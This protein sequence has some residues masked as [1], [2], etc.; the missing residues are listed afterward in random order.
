MVRHEVAQL[1]LQQQHAFIEEYRRKSK[2]TVVGYIMYLIGF[3]Y[4][5]LGR[6]GT[7]VLFYC[8]LGGLFIWAL[9]DLFRVGGMVR[10]Y[11]KDIALDVLMQLKAIQR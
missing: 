7:C 10:N 2:S 4:A 9:I 5:Y 8:T 1:N 11:N 3:H 6:W